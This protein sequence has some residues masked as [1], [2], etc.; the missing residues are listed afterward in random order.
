[1]GRRTGINYRNDVHGWLPFSVV[2]RVVGVQ[3]HDRIPVSHD[4]MPIN[5]VAK[6]TTVTRQWSR[7]SSPSNKPSS[8]SPQRK[9]KLS[10][11]SANKPGFVIVV[12]LYPL[13]LFAVSCTDMQSQLGRA[14][15]PSNSNPLIDILLARTVSGESPSKAPPKDVTAERRLSSKARR[16]SPT[17]KA[18]AVTTS[19]ESQ[20]VAGSLSY[21]TSKFML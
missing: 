17:R 2:R 18:S 19:N 5:Q 8:A 7:L 14:F 13:R 16:T 10:V 15:V 11:S 20:G 21:S 3:S 4:I 12:G 1:M 6:F 9:A